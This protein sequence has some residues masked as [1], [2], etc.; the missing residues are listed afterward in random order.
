MAFANADGGTLVVGVEDDG[1]VSGLTYG[2]DA[3]EI[4]RQAP[5]THVHSDTP[6]SG[7]RSQLVAIEEK[8]VYVFDVQK[9]TQLV[10][11]T[12][13]GRCLQRKDAETV[14]VGTEQIQF[15]RHEQTSREYDR[16]WVDGATV[17]DL[18]AALLER[19]A[20]GISPGLSSE[21]CLQSLGLAEF[22]G[23]TLRLR[24]AAL[25]LFALDINKWH[26]RC[27]I[28]FQRI[29]GTELTTGVDYNVIDD[30]PYTGNVLQLLSEGWEQIRQFLVQRR[31]AGGTFSVSSFLPRGCLP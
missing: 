3:M 10:H 11:L 31:L 1:T 5:A 14:P 15:E 4:L 6:L 23:G 13:D 2:A 22:V 30:Q 9:G 21:K 24:R 16:Q 12:S 17:A 7:V 29:A 25:L 28:R 20:P 26:P 18:N 8:T 27:E 19:V